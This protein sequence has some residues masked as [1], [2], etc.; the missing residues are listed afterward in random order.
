MTRLEEKRVGKTRVTNS[1][2]NVNP[3]CEPLSQSINDLRPSFE[4]FF[5]SAR[6]PTVRLENPALLTGEL[7]P[8]LFQASRIMDGRDFLT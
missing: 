5:P 8:G 7:K 3:V 4:E 6:L 1:R 2:K